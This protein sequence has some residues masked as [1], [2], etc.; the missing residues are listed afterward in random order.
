MSE[1]TPE[2]A[3][4]MPGG[5]DD[6]APAMPV[7]I[8]VA[9][10]GP[11]GLAAALAL[12]TTGAAIVLAGPRHS[13]SAAGFDTR[14]AALFT[15]SLALL[16]ALGAWPAVEPGSAPIAAIR[17][18]DDT[19]SLL[20]APEVLF[21]AAE[22]GLRAFGWNVP[23]SVLVQA[24][25]ARVDATAAIRWQDGRTVASLRPGSQRAVVTLDDGSRIAAR[26]V[27][28]ADGRHSPCRAGAGIETTGWEYPQTAIATSFA[29]SRPHGGVSTELHRPAGPLTVVPMPDNASSLVWVEA[30][31]IAARLMRL[32]DDGFRASLE[33][34]LMGLL[35]TVGRIGPRRAFPLGGLSAGELARS[36]VA[37]VGEAAHVIPPIG[38]QGLNLG[39]RDAAALA[40]VVADARAAGRDIGADGVLAAYA[41]A[42]RADVRARTAAVDMLNRSLL[43]DVLPMQLLRGAGLHLAKASGAARRWLIRRGLEPVGEWPRLMRGGGGV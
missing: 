16:R 15:G 2:P 7:D 25:A 29:H 21:T 27:A 43:A 17:L 42:R 31:A 1:S 4:A 39:L 28:A 41:T 3:G 12:A 9:G 10:T 13:G 19:G 14:T 40:D 32:D 34:R 30:R 18:V 5:A 6:A 38:A 20:R 11:T 35:G 33:A 24:L 36:R 8:L 23:N 37:L 22:A 26:L